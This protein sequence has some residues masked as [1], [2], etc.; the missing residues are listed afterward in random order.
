MEA[1]AAVTRGLRRGG[2]APAG[3]GGAGLALLGYSSEVKF[4]YDGVFYLFK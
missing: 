2:L 3:A 1:I 4:Y